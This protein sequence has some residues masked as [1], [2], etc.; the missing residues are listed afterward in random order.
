M[1]EKS[2][3]SLHYIQPDITYHGVIIDVGCQ[4]EGC[5]VYQIAPDH[6]FLPGLGSKINKV[7][8]HC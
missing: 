6:V 7:E 3:W 4:K 2:A 1:R 5:M 8:I